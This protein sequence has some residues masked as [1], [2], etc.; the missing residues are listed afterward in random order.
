[1][2]A[3][4]MA[5]GDYATGRFS[6]RD[7]ADRLNTQ[8]FRSRTGKLFTGASIR[9]VV[10][11]QFY[12][13]KV[14]YHKGLSDEIVVEGSHHIPKE[15]KDLWTKCQEIRTSRRNPTVAVPLRSHA[16]TFPPNQPKRNARDFGCTAR[17]MSR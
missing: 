14:V 9:D 8:G 16:P 4:L 6:Y 17:P 13:G 3:L 1:M 2:P 7:V 10:G 12:E 11:N 5:L 15:V